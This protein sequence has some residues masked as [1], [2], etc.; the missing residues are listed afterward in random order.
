MA[1]TS[2]SKSTAILSLREKVV[3]RHH[4]RTLVG[5][6]CYLGNA[7]WP[8]VRQELERWGD[9]RRCEELRSGLHGKFLAVYDPG[10]R[11]ER[12]C[13]S[14]KRIAWVIVSGY[15]LPY[16]SVSNLTQEPSMPGS[17]GPFFSARSS[18]NSW[19]RFMALN[20][21]RRCWLRSKRDRSTEWR[22]EQDSAPHI[23]SSRGWRALLVLRWNNATAATYLRLQTQP[24]Q[25]T[26]SRD[27]RI[28]RSATRCMTYAPR[29]ATWPSTIKHLFVRKQEH[30]ISQSFS[31]SFPNPREWCHWL[32]WPALDRLGPP[33]VFDGCASHD[34]RG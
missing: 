4:R 3:C 18:S 17:C 9:G 19:I 12:P 20:I 16:S 31:L 25:R 5:D 13:P 27:C 34:Q 2:N 32:D 23:S 29:I 7:T 1:L 11:Q 26:R 8:C 15:S 28:A 6:H 30:Q 14:V 24:Y 22:G 21:G 10:H 33:S